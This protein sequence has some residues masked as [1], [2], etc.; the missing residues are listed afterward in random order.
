MTTATII[1]TLSE[2]VIKV[3]ERSH[4]FSL[5]PTD[6][7][8]NLTNSQL[9]TLQEVDDWSQD[10]DLLTYV[11][12]G[13]AGVGKTTI[14]QLI[15]K[16]LRKYSMA[17]LAPTHKACKVLSGM[18]GLEAVTAHALLGLR[19]NLDLADLDIHKLKF[20]QKEK[21]KI[22]E[23]DLIICDEASMVSSALKELIIKEATKSRTRIIFIGDRFQLPPPGEEVSPV[24]AEADHISYMDEP[25]RQH[26]DNPLTLPLAALRNDMEP[27]DKSIKRVIDLAILFGMD[28]DTIQLLRD[29][30]INMFKVLI[31]NKESVMNDKGEGYTIMKNVGEFDDK[32]LEAFEE[33]S[34]DE[35]NA[36][37]FL[38][39]MNSRVRDKNLIIREKLFP[40]TCDNIL[41]EGDWLLSYTSIFNE[42]TKTK[43]IT[44]SAEY[45]VKSITNGIKYHKM[46][47]ENGHSVE[48]ALR[49]YHVKLK[50]ITD[51]DTVI[52]VVNP[53]DYHIYSELHDYFHQNGVAYGKWYPYYKFAHSALVLGDVP[54]L[55]KGQK[56][57]KKHLDYAFGITVHKSQ[58]STFRNVY[59]DGKNIRDSYE[60]SKSVF[61]KR[62]KREPEK[63]DL[64]RFRKF[65]F[66]LMYVAVSR[67]SNHVYIY[68]T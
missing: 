61:K 19:P 42:T 20:Q 40:D 51:N 1:E 39:F 10:E 3:I 57:P 35:P 44:N 67:A 53:D 52:S 30:P 31:R 13:E 26:P 14:T 68:T 25:A 6:N 21:A 33:V 8:W 7:K 41:N 27:T 15:T 4:Q 24:F 45:K 47:D 58:G 11:I 16:L 55:Y 9:K 28:E 43:I 59:I 18:T 32:L 50:G 65:V 37:R 17:L 63:A 2:R 49:V 60:I 62:Y 66:Q 64:L 46:I 29:N 22:K 34:V 56:V 38:S 48:K 54:P 23:Y 12:A 36:C 5:D